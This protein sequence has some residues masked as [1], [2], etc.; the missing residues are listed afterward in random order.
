MFANVSAGAPKFAARTEGGV[1][2]NQSVTK[3]VLNSPAAPSSKQ[4]TNSAPSG[5]RPCRECG[6]PAGKLGRL[7]PM[8]FANA[9]GRQSHI[10]A[11]DG[12]RNREVRLRH[13]PR[14]AAVLDA[15]W[16]VVERGP[17]LGHAGNVGWRRRKCRRKLI[18]DRRVLRPWIRDAR[19]IFGVDRALRGLVRIAEG[20]RG[21]CRSGHRHACGCCGENITSRKHG[22]LL[23]C[24]GTHR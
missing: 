1:W 11:G 9:A 4:R 12:F 6:Y 7:V 8:Q 22:L 13:L 23:A 17:N 20:R 5:A 2:A 3:R 19:R 21:R 16:C 15:A 18:P 24:M 10:H 14:P